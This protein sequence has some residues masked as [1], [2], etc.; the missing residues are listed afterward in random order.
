MK[1]SL[2]TKRPTI[3]ACVIALHAVAFSFVAGSAPSP[4]SDNLPHELP[5][6]AELEILEELVAWVGDGADSDRV[7]LDEPLG[8]A[9]RNRPYSF[10]LFRGYHEESVGADSLAGLPFG[11][12]IGRTAERY[13]LDALLLASV[14]EAE[15]S[16][17]P[18]VVSIKGAVGLMQVMPET[19]GLEAEALME[20]DANLTAGAAYLSH[21]LALYQGDLE[22]ALAA[23]NA[24]PGAVRRFGGM[25]PYRETRSYV[26][27]V[28][29]RYVRHHRDRWQDSESG[30]M[31][32]LL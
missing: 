32:A 26:E 6:P 7:L 30:E 14:I 8:Q 13:G 22:L 12:L 27:R 18:E 5:D 16:F 29:A 20:P 11:D 23:Y 31:L 21:L 24:G 17:N 28:L 1:I 25:P 4:S 9:I 19:A 10:E 15:S 3:R 2:M